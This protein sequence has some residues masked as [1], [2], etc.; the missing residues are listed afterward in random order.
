M[1]M[2][3]NKSFFFQIDSDVTKRVRVTCHEWPRESLLLRSIG[4][5]S[6]P[7]LDVAPPPGT[8]L[9]DTALHAWRVLSSK[10][11]ASGLLCGLLGVPTQGASKSFKD[12]APLL[13]SHPWSTGTSASSTRL[14]LV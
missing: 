8:C 10:L 11:L 5:G 3:G 7:L 6:N 14:G 4:A 9:G 13:T 12:F 1:G 2:R